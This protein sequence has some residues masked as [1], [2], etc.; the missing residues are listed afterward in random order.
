[1][2]WSKLRQVTEAWFAPEVRGRVALH[3]TAY[4]TTFHITR[5]DRAWITIDGREVVNMPYWGS[6]ERDRNVHGR[7]DSWDLY[8]SMRALLTCTIDE[9]LAGK[10]PGRDLGTIGFGGVLRALALLDARVGRRRLATLDPAAE[11]PL[12]AEL[13]R[14]RL[15][16]RTRPAANGG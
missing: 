3:M 8:G 13:L 6:Y 14:F 12:A 11:L 15:A 1:M 2:R 4:R 9:A 7:Y 16:A 10:F 5:R